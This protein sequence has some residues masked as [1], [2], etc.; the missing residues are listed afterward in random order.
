M[1]TPA[2]EKSWVPLAPGERRVVGVLV[3]KAKTTPENYPLSLNALV[4][5]CNQKS[6]RDPVTS[7][8]EDDVEEILQGLMQKGVVVR[9]EGTGRVTRWKHTM[10]DWLELRNQPVE[11]AVLT[12]LLLRGPQTEGDL[13]ARASRMESIPDLATLQGVLEGLAARG[14]VVQLTP[15]GQKRGVVV[16]HGLYPPE[17][18]ER[19][20]ELYAS[21]TLASGPEDRPPRAESA[22]SGWPAEVAA[23]RAEIAALR[24]NLASLTADVQAIKASLGI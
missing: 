21:G 5:G 20:Q 24:E 22:A 11:L 6:N 23:L 9:V 19:I 12:E 1:S 4:S 14:L 2:A 15:P 10:Y 16:T 17:E 7:Y 18:L 3:E 8:D 13:R